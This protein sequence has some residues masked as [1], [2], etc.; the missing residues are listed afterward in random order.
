[1]Y[2]WMD[3]GLFFVCRICGLC[4]GRFIPDVPHWHEHCRSGSVVLE[5]HSNYYSTDVTIA[6][7]SGMNHLWTQHTQKKPSVTNLFYE[8]NSIHN[9]W[10]CFRP[11]YEIHKR[12][13]NSMCSV[14]RQSS[15]E[16]NTL[17]AQRCRIY[18]EK[19]QL[20]RRL[21]CR[22]LIPR[23]KALIINCA[24][25]WGW[26]QNMDVGVH[27]CVC[28]GIPTL[29]HKHTFSNVWRA[30]CSVPGRFIALLFVC[31]RHL[32]YR[33]TKP[34]DG[35]VSNK[36]TSRSQD[37]HILCS[38]LLGVEFTTNS[39]RP[40]ERAWRVARLGGESYMFVGNYF[41]IVLTFLSLVN[42]HKHTHKHIRAVYV[43]GGK[44]TEA[45]AFCILSVRDIIAG[46]FCWMSIPGR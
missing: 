32:T 9:G 33:H 21:E 26:K 20:E 31:W 22:R 29:A 46:A 38:T 28:H 4:I 42:T 1:M 14:R 8:L 16:Y 11:T 15:M 7:C 6:L 5:Y 12:K 23:R 39:F 19:S 43:P 44:H 25:V 10:F 13:S 37:I 30:T 36:W 3:Y 24:H 45:H 27:A 40:T 35:Y 2:Y 34:H 41:C 17:S 18:R